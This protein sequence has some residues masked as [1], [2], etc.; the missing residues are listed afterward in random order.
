MFNELNNTNNV[1]I[2]II[3][4]NNFKTQHSQDFIIFGAGCAGIAITYFLKNVKKINSYIFCDNNPDKQ[5]DNA[6]VPIYSVKKTLS[7]ENAIYLI[8]FID[9]NMSK[10]QSAVMCL[11]DNGVKDDRIIL[12]DMQS[13]WFDDTC[14]SYTGAYLK[15]VYRKRNKTEIINKVEKICFLASGFS[16]DVENKSSGG[17][18]G[19]ICMQKK[20]LGDKYKDMLVE[21]PYYQYSTD[22]DM[23]FNK[24]WYIIG[25][26]DAVHTIVKNECNTI[27]IVNDLFSAFALY[28]LGKK[29]SFIF[30]G[31]GDIVQEWSLWGRKLTDREKAMIHKIEYVTIKDACNVSFPSNGAKWYFEQSLNKV[32]H[33]N[34]G[35]PLY[36]TIYDFPEEKK[37]YNIEKDESKITFLSIG[38]FTLLKGMD[39]IP[40]FIEHYIQY[41]GKKV[42]WIVVAD[43]VLKKEVSDRMKQLQE[44]G[45]I[46]YINIDYKISHAQIF[47]LMNISN[48]YLM[49]HRVSIFDF[50][51]LEAMYCNKAVIL[52]DIPGNCEYN[53]EDNIMMINDN[54]DWD[55]VCNYI[56]NYS[57][58][59]IENN[60]IYKQCFSDSMFVQR[61]NKFMDEFITTVES[62]S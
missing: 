17:S 57:Y 46:E 12:V 9:N 31:Q 24:Y 50:S 5:N 35:L 47:Y 53:I 2:K 18:I 43:G 54:I 7:E 28:I 29:Y 56:D 30:H 59:G 45:D 21:Y 51:T 16:K 58:H 10:L 27:Y 32:V 39:R 15:T 20:Y 52:S 41:T 44:N 19:A 55:T 8:G 36:N 48:I 14:I 22:M 11:K 37:V 62:K 13:S 6:T 34:S 40:E 38:Q 49:L 4:L 23:I 25:T 61:Y 60:R 1:D 42:R 3:D 33:Y 26:L